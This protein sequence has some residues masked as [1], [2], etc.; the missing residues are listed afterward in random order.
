MD[1]KHLKC[2]IAA[3]EQ[4]SFSR[5]A[6]QLF[7]TQSAVSQHIALLERETGAQLFRRTGRSISITDN[8]RYLYQRVKPLMNQLEDAMDK[9]A[10]ISTTEEQHLTVYYRGDAVDPIVTPLLKA[11]REEAP[12]CRIELLRTR[13]T[14][15]TLVSLNLQEADL[16]LLKR[17]PHPLAST[18]R[19][20]PLCL[21]YLTC[22]LPK[23]H[24]LEQRP[25]LTADDLSREH[26]ILLKPR[27][28][29]QEAASS[30]E[31]ATANDMRYQH[32]HD[33]LHRACK[34]N[35]TLTADSITALTLAKANFGITLVDSSQIVATDGLSFVPYRENRFHEYGVFA[36]PY[37]PNPL[38][39]VFFDIVAR[40]FPEPPVFEPGGK[41]VPLQSFLDEHPDMEL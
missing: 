39:G 34:T 4:G 22:V 40:L 38:I 2:F 20:H 31:N 25:Y 10:S 11:L 28:D 6:T 18:M 3:V 26:L 24:P 36:W 9:V 19:F 14:R 29:G 7:I 17:G 1:F 23:G 41:L 13:R 30:R 5:A 12:L 27:N 8:G 35:C 15:D 37:N 32:V 16:A 33:E 21:I